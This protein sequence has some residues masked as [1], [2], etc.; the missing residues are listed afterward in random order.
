MRG[1]LGICYPDSSLIIFLLS[2]SFS[3]ISTQWLRKMVPLNRVHCLQQRHDAVDIVVTYCWYSNLMLLFTCLSLVYMARSRHA[4]MHYTR[5][6]VC[7]PFTALFKLILSFT[8]H[9]F[10][11]HPTVTSPR[12]SFFS[13]SS[14]GPIWVLR[15]NQLLLLWL[16]NHQD[17]WSHPSLAYAGYASRH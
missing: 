2:L 13:S 12:L 17:L 3:V 8:S 5:I 16:F 7:L 4:H 1:P 10:P 15:I 9:L 11:Y 6:C 14:I